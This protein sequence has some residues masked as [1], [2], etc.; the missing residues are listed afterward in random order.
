MIEWEWYKDNNTKVLFLH[1]LFKANW[2]DGR[3]LGVA[4]PRGSFATSLGNLSKE[5]GLSVRQIRTALEHLKSTGEVTI[6][7]HSKFS[8]VDVT[9]YSHYQTVDIDNDKRATS[10]RQRSDKRATTIE[11]EKEEKEV[12]N[13]K[14]KIYI[15]AYHFSDNEI[16][17]SAFN[18]FIEM[19]KAI[20]K[21][22]T[23]RAIKN[24]AVKLNKLSPDIYTQA[25]ILDQSINHSWQDVY[26]LKNDFVSSRRKTKEI[27][28][29][30]E[31]EH[32]LTDEEFFAM[33]DSNFGEG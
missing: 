20:K 9:N 26:P 13:K 22:M 17:Q 30:A 16:L 15:G 8:V 11:E 7:R 12:K 18:D 27:I 21:P 23:E 25:D 32:E 3:F 19:R 1:C 6:T 29:S 28:P 4:I 31:P 10:E 24:L 33:V 5:T 14:K 2:K